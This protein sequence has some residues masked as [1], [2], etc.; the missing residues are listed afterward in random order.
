MAP[1]ESGSLRIGVSLPGVIRSDFC[2]TL[3]MTPVCCGWLDGRGV[4]VT[5]PVAW[6]SAALAVDAATGGVYLTPWTRPPV[7]RRILP[8]D[9]EGRTRPIPVREASGTRPLGRAMVG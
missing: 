1:V 2:R 4:E 3:R 9:R 5:P 6:K 8:S 7:R